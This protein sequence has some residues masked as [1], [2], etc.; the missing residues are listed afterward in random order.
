MQV[1]RH[2]AP[3]PPLP[4]VATILGDHACALLVSTCGVCECVTVAGKNMFG[5][6]HPRE[7]TNLL[8]HD[9]LH[10][11]PA[12]APRLGGNAPL[13]P[14]P[15]ARSFPKRLRHTLLAVLCDKGPTCVG[16]VLRGGCTRVVKPRDRVVKPRPE[17]SSLVTTMRPGRGF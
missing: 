8:P 10:C 4:M 1:T 14:P 6:H 5:S 13:L 16:I 7:H 15:S 2:H 9:T 3:S 12:D 17:W 11:R